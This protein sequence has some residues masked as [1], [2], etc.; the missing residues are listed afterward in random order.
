MAQVGVPNAAL[1]RARAELTLGQAEFAAAINE[2]GADA[3][4]ELRCD[5]RLVAKWEAGEVRWPLGRYRRALEAVTGESCAR[6]GFQPPDGHTPQAPRVAALTVDFTHDV[7]DPVQRRVFLAATAALATSAACPVTPTD[8]PRVIAAYVQDAARTLDQLTDIEEKFGSGNLLPLV[9]QQAAELANLVDA[10]ADT[11][12]LHSVAAWAHML[13]GWTN[14]D[15]GNQG[16][17]R[18]L[19]KDALYLAQSRPD[20]RDRGFDRRASAYWQAVLGPAE[21]A[22][23]HAGGP[24]RG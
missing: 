10:G 15:T 13:A 1:R 12:A 2:A 16:R 21:R 20:G 17:A 8:G 4:D 5:V 19:Y 9:E 11:A 24:A 23:A 7:E 22:A 14:Y 6:L 3:G 18:Y